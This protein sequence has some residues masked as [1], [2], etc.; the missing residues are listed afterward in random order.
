MKFERKQVFLLETTFSL[1]TLVLLDKNQFWI[2][3][4][5]IKTR[6]TIQLFPNQIKWSFFMFIYIIW[7]MMI[8]NIKIWLHKMFCDEHLIIQLNQSFGEAR[9]YHLANWWTEFAKQMRNDNSQNSI[10][11]KWSG[12]ERERG[13]KRIIYECSLNM[14]KW[15]KIQYRINSTNIMAVPV[16][17]N[18]MKSLI[19]YNVDDK[20]LIF[21]INRH[22]LE[23]R[24][25]IAIH[26]LTC[27]VCTKTRWNS[28]KLT[29]QLI[30]S[31]FFFYYLW[32]IKGLLILNSVQ[33]FIWFF[34]VFRH[35]NP[36]IKKIPQNVILKRGKIPVSSL[37]HKTQKKNGYAA[38]REASIQLKTWKLS[39]VFEVQLHFLFH[40]ELLL[41]L[42]C[43]LFF[44]FSS[45]ETR[46]KSQQTWFFEMNSCDEILICWR[47]RK[48]K[49]T[50]TK[51]SNRK[52]NAIKV[53]K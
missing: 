26:W 45:D 53:P 39:W 30:K 5:F 17:T 35:Q 33:Y 47:K 48:R 24:K 23:I 43:V 32:V 34:V 44:C 29:S 37:E 20:H 51:C 4:L 49:K 14:S 27:D 19:C 40:N 28:F 46:N 41:S 22:S 2:E 3:W 50:T 18:Q 7:C 6:S 42:F 12:R 25:Q 9:W 13:Q 11:L 15:S 31:V 36:I 38:I 52:Q 8:G 1:R 16:A 21:R 10:H